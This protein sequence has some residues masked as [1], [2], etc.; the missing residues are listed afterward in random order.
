MHEAAPLTTAPTAMGLPRILAKQHGWDCRGSWR[1]RV[2]KSQGTG[3]LHGNSKPFLH[4][5][6]HA[7]SRSSLCLCLLAVGIAVMG[8]I[9]FDPM[10][11][12]E[13]V[14]VLVPP[15]DAAAEAGFGHA[16]NPAQ[17]MVRREA[18]PG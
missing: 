1:S 2:A 9:G 11:M 16:A 6:L 10:V 8:R 18:P 4:L 15:S 14:R 7:I 3:H 12:P 17:V 5:R 13:L